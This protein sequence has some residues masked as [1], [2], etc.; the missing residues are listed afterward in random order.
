MSSGESNSI[1]S[2]VLPNDLEEEGCA[3]GRVRIS[4]V[5]P[6]L[7]GTRIALATFAER[8]VIA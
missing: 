6:F 2:L 4:R 8:A 1:I 3:G 7:L 5:H